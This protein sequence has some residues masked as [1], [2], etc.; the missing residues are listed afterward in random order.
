MFGKKTGFALFCAAFSINTFGQK[1][2]EIFIR[3][4]YTERPIPG[5]WLIPDRTEDTLFA[6]DDG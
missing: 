5:A 4:A 6:A 1:T 3:D 2:P